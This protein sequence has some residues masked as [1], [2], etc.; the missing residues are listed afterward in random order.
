MIIAGALSAAA[1]GM[2]SAPAPA[3]VMSPGGIA[4]YVDM[5]FV[6]NRAFQNNFEVNLAGLLTFTRA[7]PATAYYEQADGSLIT[8][9]A[10]VPRIGNR[11][12][13]S[14][15]TRT[16]VVLWNRD[17]TN[18][19]W[20][21]VNATAAQ[22]QTGPDG[23]VNGASSLTAT[24]AN[25]TCSQAIV[26]ASSARWQS[27][28]I[29]RLTGTGVIEMSMDG[30]AT[31]TAIVPTA[32]WTAVEIPTQTLANPSPVFRIVTSG[33]SI[34]LD[35]VQNENDNLQRSSPIAT[36]TAA[37]ARSA[38]L[39][40]ET[41]FPWINTAGMTIYAQGAGNVPNS[42]TL[43]A[44]FQLDHTSGNALLFSRQS[45]S[46]ATGPFGRDAALVTQWALSVDAGYY[47]N[48]RQRSIQSIR[49]NDITA[50]GNR[51]ILA[52]DAAA[53]VPTPFD[54]V[55]IGSQRTSQWWNGYIERFAAWNSAVS[56]DNVK[57]LSTAN[58]EVAVFVEGDS[59][60]VSPAVITSFSGYIR[61]TAPLDHTTRVYALSGSTVQG[62]TSLTTRLA[63]VLADVQ[64]FKDLNPTKKRIMVLEIGHNDF[65]TLGL[66]TATFLSQLYAY[67]DQI[68]AAG[69][70]V[71]IVSLTPSTVAGKNTFRNT[72]NTDI[73]ANVSIHL[74]YYVDLSLTSVGA[75]ADGSDVA[76]YSDGIH[77]TTATASI[78]GQA[79]LDQAISIEAAL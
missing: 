29:K 48:R 40:L 67:T 37:V 70:K 61:Q 58:T 2:A 39:I 38:D 21:K 72:C 64:F 74:D 51:G 42:S 22:D 76:K 7:A 65:A 55:A 33:D 34:A 57:R 17:L 41:A 5:D 78:I 28:Y 75:D 20:I 59:I 10:N 56:D 9:A 4:P 66:S 25:G 69:V 36:T 35:F 44:Y 54:R 31:Y 6:D 23:T 47:S 32:N 8:F 63:T 12:I 1:R 50:S 62:A 14:E 18:V 30:G 19:I 3:W 52:Q 53:T 11:G 26:L 15:E 60:P 68:R 45:A 43:G 77:P 27:A 46:D 24:A 73:D 71:A 49:L 13:L 16:N 79:C